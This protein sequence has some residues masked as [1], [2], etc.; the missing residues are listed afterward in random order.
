MVDSHVIPE[1][2]LG[3]LRAGVDK[4]N[5]R[6]VKLGMT[7]VGL[8]VSE[9]RIL[10]RGPAW[11][12]R[13][14]WVVDVQLTGEAPRI[15]GFVFAARLEHLEGGNLILRAPGIETDLDGWRT[16][17]SRCQHCGLDRRRSATFL[18][19]NAD[20]A[21]IQVGKSCLED[22][23]G[24]TN[25]ESAVDLFK[26]WAELVAGCGEEGEYGFGGGWVPDT[27]P[28]EYLAAAIASIRAR[29]FHKSG[30]E[31]VSTK[32]DCDFITGPCPKD[33]GARGDREM[34]E[35]W[36]KSQ[37]SEAQRAEAAAIL[38]WALASNDS[39]DYMHNARLLCGAR[40]VIDRARGILASL[41][42]A[43]DKALGRERERQERPAPGPHVG[44][45]G[46]RIVSKI[47]VK[48]VRGYT[49]DF[50]EGVMLLMLDEKNS[51][52]KTFSS[53]QL[54]NVEDFD[55]EW[56]LIGTVK[57]HETDQKYGHPVT[58]LSRVELRKTE[59]Y[60]LPK[61]KK[62]KPAT[63]GLP[64]YSYLPNGTVGIVAYEWKPPTGVSFSWEANREGVALHQ[65][66]AKTW[67]LTHTPWDLPGYQPKTTKAAS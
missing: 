39:S 44:A 20:G 38:A 53:G 41:P 37:P 19:Q 28:V 2:R 11:E 29:G 25:V 4:L 52:L 16:T 36:K 65:A 26:C 31:G 18:L 45:I 46:E 43:Y 64:F 34:I 57:K 21:L 3:L 7:P 56:F 58:L 14:I 59:P 5:K 66:F 42:V 63:K 8:I 9:P 10:R 6:A 35:D 50:G 23:T 62:A 12:S 22:Y 60:P 13:D 1:N 54:S 30:C 15:G 27:M 55:G 51:A 33:K 61:P 47:T 49:N 67:Q 48:L 17:G 40:T 24:T 32:R